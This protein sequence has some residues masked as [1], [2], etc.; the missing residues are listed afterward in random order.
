MLSL[1]IE[2]NLNRSIELVQNQFS[3][4]NHKH[5]TQTE[6]GLPVLRRSLWF[7]WSRKW[8]LLFL[9][10][11]GLRSCVPNLDDATSP[12]SRPHVPA[13]PCRMS[14]HTCIPTSQASRPKHAS[15]RPCPHI[16]VPLL[17]TVGITADI[18]HHNSLEFKSKF[19]KNQRNDF[20]GL[21]IQNFPALLAKISNI[22][23][24]IDQFCNTSWLKTGTINVLSKLVNLILAH[25]FEI[26]IFMHAWSRKTQDD[27]FTLRESG[28]NLHFKG[29][30]RQ[31]MDYI[32]YVT[33]HFFKYTQ[34]QAVRLSVLFL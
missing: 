29:R 6:V 24:V 17:V 19:L 9:T 2:Q 32:I 28:S 34:T 21:C 27:K 8:F 7:I 18:S 33:S 31:L 14:P 15:Q 13:S 16:P 26:C 30:K 1:L 4:S 22:Q 20:P 11:P 10:S 12:I 23:N 3:S 5:T 25:I